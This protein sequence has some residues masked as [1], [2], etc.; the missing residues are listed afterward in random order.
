MSSRHTRH[1]VKSVLADVIQNMT[2]LDDASPAN[3]A[4]LIALGN[5]LV[6]AQLNNALAILS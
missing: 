2:A 6:A 1:I 4:A 5:Q 3:I